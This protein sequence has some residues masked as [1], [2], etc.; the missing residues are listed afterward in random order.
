MKKIIEKYKKMNFRTKSG[1]LVIFIGVVVSTL[2]IIE[3]VTSPVPSSQEPNEVILESTG[4]GHVHTELPEE[5][6][7]LEP[8]TVE[9]R[10][11]EFTIPSNWHIEETIEGLKISI[12]HEGQ[13]HILL[14]G[15]MTSSIDLPLENNLA[16][17]SYI[18]NDTVPDFEFEAILVSGLPALRHF[19]TIQ[20]EDVYHD[21]VGFLFPNGNEL[22]Y[23]QFGTPSEGIADEGLL[24]F[25]TAIILTLNLPPNGFP[26]VE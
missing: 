26:S 15:T 8:T 12:V 19:Y 9:Y 21:I 25:V 3:A 24:Q 4:G 13:G 11:L 1:I 17:I 5:N 16:L 23:A 18:F 10:G 20:V 6:Y 22:I 14:I 7:L 2:I